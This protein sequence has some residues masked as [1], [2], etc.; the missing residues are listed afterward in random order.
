MM[1]FGDVRVTYHFE[2]CILYPMGDHKRR[3][4]IQSEKEETMRDYY[5]QHGMFY[6]RKRVSGFRRDTVEPGTWVVF[7]ILTEH[8]LGRAD[9]SPAE[10]REQ[11]EK[12]AQPSLVRARARFAGY[13]GAR[14]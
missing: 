13:C 4:N 5:E 6:K 1:M 11:A 10:S 9:H 7:L 8:L 3:Y 12:C 2:K 14:C